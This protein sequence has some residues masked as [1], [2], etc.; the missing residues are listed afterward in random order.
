MSP[1]PPGRRT[2]G[3]EM[4]KHARIL[5]VAARV[6]QA[7]AAAISDC[8]DAELRLLALLPNAASETNCWW[9]TWEI[10]GPLAESAQCTLQ[11]R[12]NARLIKRREKR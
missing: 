9:L 11:S 6:T 2:I 1:R 7:L 8:T 12:K 10:R 4:T 3:A 5:K